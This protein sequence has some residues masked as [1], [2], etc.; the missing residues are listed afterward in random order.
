M[1]TGLLWHDDDKKKTLESKINEA[2][3]RYQQRFHAI[4]NVCHVHGN[5]DEERQVIG[6]IA[7]VPNPAIRPNYYWLG[8]EAAL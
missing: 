5:G 7:I 2:S 3:V 1:N 6:K 8:V 4:P